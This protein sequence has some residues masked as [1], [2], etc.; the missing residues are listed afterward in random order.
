MKTNILRPVLLA[1]TLLLGLYSCEKAEKNSED[2]SEGAT[3]FLEL[4]TRLNAMNTNNGQMGNFMS[5]IAQSQ[6]SS[7]NMQFDGLNVDSSYAEYYYCET[8]DNPDFWGYESCATITESDNQDGTHTTVYDYGD[9]CEEYGSLLKGKI[10]YVWSSQGS[11]YY[12]KV[13]YDQYYSYG[14]MMNGYSE[15]SFTSDGESYFNFGIETTPAGVFGDTSV[16]A[17]DSA[18]IYPDYTFN[19][20]GTSEGKDD[21]VVVFDNG[22]G[23]TYSSEYSNKWDNASYTVLVGSYDYESKAEGYEFHYEVTSPLIT[24]YECMNAFIP[25]SGIESTTYVEAS[26]VSSFTVDYGNG[27]CDNLAEVTENGKTSIV[28]FGELYEIYYD[29]TISDSTTVTPVN[30]WRL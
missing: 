18:V 2:L 3:K 15:Y 1:A 24:N 14:L 26:L 29:G 6:L 30:G 27:T 19:W 5:V 23:Y 8:C 7:G 4:K 22:E 17:G 13:I 21:Y 10:T 12:S 25:V 11:S 9:G 28:D 16:I 20:S